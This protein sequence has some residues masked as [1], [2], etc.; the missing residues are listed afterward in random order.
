MRRTLPT[1]LILPWVTLFFFLFPYTQIIH[2]SSYTQ[3]YGLALALFVAVVRP[4]AIRALPQLDRVMLSSLVVA[5]LLMLLFEIPFGIDFREISFFLSYATPVFSTVAAYWIVRRY[6][7][8]ARKMLVGAIVVWAGVSLIQTFVSPTF[9]TQFVTRDLELGA[10]IRASGRGVLGLA[11]EPTHNA[12]H[13]L[14]MGA[15][16]A[17]AGGPIWA[18]ALA[19]LNAILLAR[20]ASAVLALAMGGLL[21]SLRRPVRRFWVLLP[22]IALPTVISALAAVSSDTTRLGKII[23]QLKDL[24]PSLVMLDYSVNARISGATMPVLYAFEDFL[25]PQGISLQQWFDVRSAILAK[26]AWVID[27]SFAGPASGIGL[28]LLQG[29]LLALPFV[30][31][32][33]FRLIVQGGQAGLMGF[34]STLVF[35]I[36]LGQFYFA[37]P[38]FGLFLAVLILRIRSNSALPSRVTQDWGRSPATAGVLPSWM[39][40]RS[41]RHEAPVPVSGLP[42]PVPQPPHPHTD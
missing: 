25:I 40:G 21:W 28:F 26:H 6:P 15:A 29:G 8:M 4:G 14:L 20:S 9:L 16:L 34:G 24:D 7:T 41:K 3:P 10:N 32:L 36:F 12:F 11:P 13:S 27:L 38:T 35:A 17:L 1:S 22:L 18:V 23:S 5:G 37:T 31:Y 39:P 2:V 42:R 19:M 33:V 30:V